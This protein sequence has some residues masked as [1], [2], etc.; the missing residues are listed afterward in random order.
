MNLV[1][2]FFSYL[3]H[4][5]IMPTYFF[6]LMAF[7]Y[8]QALEPIQSESHLLFVG[9]VFLVTFLVPVLNLS[10]L[11]TFG[12]I[13]SFEMNDRRDRLVPFTIIS[14]VYVFITYLFYAKTR[15]DITDNFLKL[16][17]VIDA[18]AVLATLFTFFFKISIHSLVS[19]GIIGML[20][21]LHKISGTGTLYYPILIMILLTGIIM[22]SRIYL[23]EHSLS[24]VMWG[25]VV[26]LASSIAGM[27]I[28]FQ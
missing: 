24:E 27:I 9:L 16:M 20:I 14:V 6:A 18:L 21:P 5:L 10:I 25:S 12:T 15:I 28:L 19:W 8:P 1:A 7:Q 23:R 11:K 3:F 13:K 26:G 4:P 17:I 22:S 2:K